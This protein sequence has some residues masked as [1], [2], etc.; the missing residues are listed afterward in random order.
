MRL[1]TLAAAAWLL[2][3]ILALSLIGQAI[4]RLVRFALATLLVAFYFR[5][6]IVWLGRARIRI[7]LAAGAGGAGSLRLA[8]L[9]AARLLR[10][11]R[12][13]LGTGRRLAL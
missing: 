5:L 10:F 13:F 1:A 4:A 2:G 11:V 6:L 12:A 3:R 7:A 8:T 9:L